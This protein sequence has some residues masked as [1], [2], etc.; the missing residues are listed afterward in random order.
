M[1]YISHP[2][3]SR[4]VIGVS[5]LI[6]LIGN[7]LRFVP[8]LGRRLRLSVARGG[9]PATATRLFVSRAHSTC[10][11]GTSGDRHTKRPGGAFSPTV[12]EARS[13][14]RPRAAPLR[15]HLTRRQPRTAFVAHQWHFAAKAAPLRADVRGKCGYFISRIGRLFWS[16][17]GQLRSTTVNN[18]QKRPTVVR[19][20]K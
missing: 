6:S 10:R 14:D 7:H 18:G 4:Y 5:S 8:R 20:R 19:D 17:S 1:A 9:L 16:V 13:H 15:R 11:S 3:A 12:R 2:E